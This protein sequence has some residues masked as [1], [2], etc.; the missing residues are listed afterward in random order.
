[1]NESEVKIWILVKS[2]V[3]NGLITNLKSQIEGVI[4]NP[5]TILWIPDMKLTTRKVMIAVDNDKYRISTYNFIGNLSE[6]IAR[7]K[8][9]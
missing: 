8:K 2:M 4:P 5:A 1:M 7:L 3:K 9:K 6:T